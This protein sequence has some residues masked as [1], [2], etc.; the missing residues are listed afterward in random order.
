[1]S[2]DIVKYSI[3]IAETTRSL[4]VMVNDEMKK[5]WFPLGSVYLNESGFPC[6]PVVKYSQKD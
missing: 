1:M 6:Q 4:A 5:G 2:T 3:L